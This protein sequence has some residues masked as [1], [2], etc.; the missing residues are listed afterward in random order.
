[1]D[2]YLAC[3]V[4]RENFIFTTPASFPLPYDEILFANRTNLFR[5]REPIFTKRLVVLADRYS[6]NL[7]YTPHTSKV[8][9]PPNPAQWQNPTPPLN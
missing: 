1:M 3:D 4:K 8:S 9:L 7:V 2:V 5:E 6:V